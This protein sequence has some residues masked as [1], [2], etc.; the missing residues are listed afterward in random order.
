MDPAYVLIV[1]VIRREAEVSRRESQ[2]SPRLLDIPL[3][4]PYGYP[5]VPPNALTPN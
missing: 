5:P 3:C 1:S 4:L 2:V